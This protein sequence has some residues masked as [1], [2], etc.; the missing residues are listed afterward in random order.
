MSTLDYHYISSDSH[1]NPPTA[2][3]ADYLAS[4]FRDRA[5][6]VEVTDDGDFEIFEGKRKPIA[7]LSS[8]AGRR[9]EEYTATVRRFSDVRAGGHEPAARLEDQD[10]DGVD[11]E[12]LFGAVG[13]APLV[14]EDPRLTRASFTAYNRWLAD[15]CNYSPNRLIGMAVIPC[16]DV[17]DAITEAKDAA[18]HGLRGAVIPHSAG[19]GEFR[20]DMWDPFFRTLA[21]LDW[22]A[23]LHVSAGTRRVGTGFSR[24][25]Q[26]MNHVVSTKFEVALSLGRFV[27]GGVLAKHPD[28]K[29]VSVEGQI[30]WI[31]F[32]KYYV[33]HVYE[34]HRWHTDTHL[35]ERPSHYIERQVWFTFMEDPA[36]IEMRHECGLDRI[37]WSSDY[38]HSETTW[39]HSQKIIGE[40]FERIPADEVRKIVRDNCADLYHI[41]S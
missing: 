5:P 23:H 38:P 33:D 22:P 36:G 30:G 28:L 26:F 31:P 11:A 20:D 13:D 16:D 32:W 39:P 41:T 35:A 17:D 15:F 2:M 40:I 37:M 21:E 8:M 7:H 34:K 18:A 24:G 6:R 3:W 25:D 14:S 19:V 29:L 4:E 1:V 10:I 12:I 9:P 27:L